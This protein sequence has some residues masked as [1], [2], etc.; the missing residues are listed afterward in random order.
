MDNDSELLRRYADERSEAAFT[1]VVERH[2]NLVYSAALREVGGDTASA[3][4]LSQAVFTELAR[5]AGKLRRHPAL[6]G[7]LYT[8]VRRLAANWR[9]SQQ[10]RAERELAAHTM[11]TEGPSPAATDALWQELRPVLDD[12]MHELRA[13]D[14]TAVV[15]RFFEDRSLKQVGEALGVNENAA[16]MRVDR[17]L[18]ASQTTMIKGMLQ[19]KQEAGGK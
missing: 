1:E 9:R 8:A 2:V 18:Q 16:R 15:L 13:A 12:A 6:A 11:M 7:W 10:H 5:Q 19:A 14:R 3:E 17:K 4:D